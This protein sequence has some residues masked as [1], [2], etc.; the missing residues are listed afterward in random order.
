MQSQMGFKVR[1]LLSGI[2]LLFVVLAIIGGIR[3][4]S[5]VPFW[6]MWDGYLSFFQQ[7]EAGNFSAWWAQ[8]NEH[9]IFWS[10]VL[11]WMDLAW[12]DGR[13]W[14]LIA[15]NYVLVAASVVL[16]LLILQEK[17]HGKGQPGFAYF[18]GV[19]VCAW[20]FSWVQSENLTW[21][22]QSQ[23][24]LA[25]LVTLAAF[26]S[27]CKASEYIAGAHA[28]RWYV[29]A[30]CLGLAAL[31]TMANGVLALPLMVVLA[32]ALRLPWSRVV[33]L[34]ALAAV[35]CALYFYDYEPVAGHGSLTQA[36]SEDPTG[37]IAYTLLYLGGP[38][39]FFFGK[40]D[41]GTYIGQAMG[42]FLVGSCAGFL[43]HALRAPESNKLNLALLAFLV[44]VGGTAFAT[45]GGRLVFG[46]QTT[47]RY[48]TPALMA[49]AALLLLYIPCLFKV[50]SESRAWK[51]A[52]PFG[53]LLILMFARQV[54]ALE[55]H[56]PELF[57]RKVA[58]LALALQV[59][60][61]E[62]I[63]KIY[64]RPE[65]ALQIARRA[66]NEKQAIFGEP[67][68]KSALE[69]IG[70]AYAPSTSLKCAG[71]V[72]KIEPLSADNKFA[73]VTGRVE[74]PG[75][76]HEADSILLVDD[77]GTVIGYALASLQGL[78]FKGYMLAQNTDNALLTPSRLRVCP[79]R[80]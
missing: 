59:N 1:M 44:F 9:R 80:F 26:Y 51:W 21:G 67:Y 55:S 22:F 33:V 2:A 27:L 23:F 36:L 19:F 73:R 16:F 77:A 70:S 4:Y 50:A 12:F 49:W 43:F 6:D 62:Q 54:K 15:V 61:Q 34:F 39:Y 37:V 8:H 35:G 71:E 38:F 40:G 79:V 76:G 68:I 29:L 75:D 30:C 41:V 42:L 10:R 46:I 20:L 56:A 14:F 53:I 17:S 57:E 3:N 18:L 31:G 64:P 7:V 66:I 48:M 69:L 32:V 78:S 65:H 58:V 11:F 72:E 47:S 5:P 28:R 52:V 60:D 74:N 45:S 24:F 63:H 13:V 25:Q